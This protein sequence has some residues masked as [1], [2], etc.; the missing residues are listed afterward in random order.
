ML[1]CEENIKTERQKEKFND[2]SHILVP[3]MKAAV[4]FPNDGC[5]SLN[6]VFKFGNHGM[7]LH[8]NAF[9]FTMIST[10]LWKFLKIDLEMW[11]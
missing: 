9:E 4:S 6:Q 1:W 7:N 10:V 3:I 11:T 8:K 2:R 5:D